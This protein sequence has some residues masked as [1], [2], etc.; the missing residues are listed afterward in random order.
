[1]N[2]THLRAYK[3]AI[4]EAALSRSVALEIELAVGFA[5]I[6]EC[7]GLKR[8]ARETLLAIYAD[9]G[10]QCTR[11]GDVD[12]KAINRRIS[13]AIALYEFIGQADIAKWGEGTKLRD[14]VEA[15]RPHIA[16]LKLKSVNEVLLACDK[17]RAP[18]KAP[19]PRGV[20]IETK[21]VHLSIPPN[22]TADELMDIAGK[23]MDMARNMFTQP[24]AA[25]PENSE[26]E[27][28]E[29]VDA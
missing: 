24:A 17:I 3:N 21:H 5:V 27:S 7:D 15:F 6:L 8:L 12:W 1:M 2:K 25:Q 18:R 13:A 26:A 10:S 29:T 14:Q 16:A 19:E 11:P 9:A 23:L 22:A 4:V 28:G 20:R